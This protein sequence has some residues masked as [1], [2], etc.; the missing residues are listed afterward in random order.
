LVFNQTVTAVVHILG[1][2]VSNALVLNQSVVVKIID[3]ES[4]TSNLALNQLATVNIVDLESASNDLELRQ[5]ALFAFVRHYMMLQA[6]WG[7]IEQTVTLPSP[8]LQDAENLVDTITINYAEDGTLY[9]YVKSQKERRLNYTFSLTRQ[10][11]L[12]LQSFIDAWN[13]DA[14]KMLNWKGE[15]WKV[16]LVTNPIE[17]VPARRGAPCGPTTEVSFTLEGEKIL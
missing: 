7:A 4:V 13:S 2:R 5:E 9:T 12:E 14:W 11:S 8:E 3:K 15:I 10:K 17:F 16:K 6:P 1:G